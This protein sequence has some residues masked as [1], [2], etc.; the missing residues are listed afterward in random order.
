[1]TAADQHV[2]PSSP[3]QHIVAI[4]RSGFSTEPENLLLEEFI[5]SLASDLPLFERSVSRSGCCPLDSWVDERHWPSGG[6]GPVNGQ[7][8]SPDWS[9]QHVQHRDCQESAPLV[10]ISGPPE[11][12]PI[13]AEGLEAL[14]RELHDLETTGRRAI[15][16]RI[17]T[18]RELGDLSENA[19]YHAAKED[20]A[21]M[22]TQIKRLKQRLRSAVVTEI[23]TEGS[24]FEF[25]RTAEVVD[26]STG[27][28][29]TWTIVGAAEADLSQGRLSASSPVAKALIG[30]EIGAVVEVATPKGSRRLRIQRLL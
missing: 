17:L 10:S 1:M 4:G 21:H 5:L 9:C 14:K 6:T 30:Q 24:T 25:G 28:V 18:A 12:E 8:A 20:Q 22:E 3:A 11:G 16:A 7:H 15:A 26:E 2:T 23:A 27:V 13:S 19:E 29:N